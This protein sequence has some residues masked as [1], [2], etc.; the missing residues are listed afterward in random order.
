V[1][2]VHGLPGNLDGGNRR[3]L[4]AFIAVLDTANP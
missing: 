4:K 2:T 3:N 1:R